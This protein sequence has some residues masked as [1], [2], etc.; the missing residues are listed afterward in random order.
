MKWLNVVIVG[1]VGAVVW[2]IVQDIYNNSRL[3]TDVVNW[4]DG[5]PQNK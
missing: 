4:M 1:A 5:K 3:H 2:L